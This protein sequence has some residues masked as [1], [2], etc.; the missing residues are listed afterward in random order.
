MAQR[1]DRVIDVTIPEGTTQGTQNI[2]RNVRVIQ[3]VLDGQPFENTTVRGENLVHIKLYDAQTD[4][5]LGGVGWGGGVIDGNDVRPGQRML[6]S[7][8]S[9]PVP[10]GVRRI[11]YEVI[12]QQ[13]F[14]CRVDVDL[15][16][17][18]DL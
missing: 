6:W 16:F 11:R 2:P 1:L 13:S 5:Y 17:D 12:A 14:Q 18:E 4:N 10:N 3:V 8:G 7:S 9:W 15:F